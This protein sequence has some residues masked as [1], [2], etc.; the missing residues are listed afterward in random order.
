MNNLTEEGST[1]GKGSSSSYTSGD[2]RPRGQIFR[3]SSTGSRTTSHD[4]YNMNALLG[5]MVPRTGVMGIKEEIIP[6][7]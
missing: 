6:A 4:R 7:I 2:N 5:D 3:G 1:R